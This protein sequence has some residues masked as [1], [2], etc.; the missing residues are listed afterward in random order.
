M[1]DTIDIPTRSRPEPVRQPDIFPPVAK[2]RTFTPEEKARLVAES[3]A[4][5][6]SVCAFARRHHIAASQLFAWRKIARQGGGTALPATVPAPHRHDAQSGRRATSDAT[7]RNAGTEE[8]HHRIFVTHA[9]S[10][11][12]GA[13]PE[14]PAR[15]AARIEIAIGSAV[16]RVPSGIDRATLKLVLDTLRE[17]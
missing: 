12:S 1:L 10:L 3:L 8:M 14:A 4:S 2:R 13:W 6:E 15:C 9:D 17:A 5:H 7:A 11:C 16:V